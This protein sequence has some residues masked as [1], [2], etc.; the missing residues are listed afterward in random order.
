MSPFSRHIIKLIFLMDLILAVGILAEQK[1][2][3]ADA[4]FYTVFGRVAGAPAESYAQLHFPHEEVKMESV[5]RCE[6]RR[7]YPVVRHVVW[8]AD[9][10]EDMGALPLPKLQE[11]A[12]ILNCLSEKAGAR[13]VGISTPLVWEDEH[14]EMARHMLARAL[15]GFRHACIGLPARNAAQAEATPE[16]LRAAALPGR[17]IEGNPAAL[18]YANAP[19]PAASPGAEASAA[20]LWA[21]DYVEDEP[22]ADYHVQGRS[23]PLLMRW[24]GEVLPTLPLRLALAQ[25]GLSP[26]DVQVKLGKSI[27]IGSRLLP[28]DE[29]GCTPLGAA[30]VEPLPLAELLTAPP[31]DVQD[32]PPAI[33]S[34]AF[35]PEQTPQRGE[36]LAATLSLLLSADRKVYLP[37]ERPAGNMLLELNPLQSHLVGRIFLAVLAV[38]ALVWLPL[39][40]PRIRR[41]ALGA[42][43]GVF[44]LAAIVWFCMGMWMSLCAGWLCWGLLAGAV[45]LLGRSVRS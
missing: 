22:A 7:H 26:A 28:L 5:I 10:R 36:Q 4:F 27:R 17:N 12:T 38:C 37:T 19:L 41:I 34:R 11:L 29:R 39:A 31:R 9:G 13:A 35:T 45:H 24:R 8:E 44:C 30:R 43:A 16:A 23:C 3:R 2:V 25:L 14:D 20:L 33:I 21:P 32:A 1:L 18:P 40:A 6:A 42:A 15:K